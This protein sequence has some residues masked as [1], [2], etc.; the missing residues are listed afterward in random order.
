MIQTGTIRLPIDDETGVPFA[1]SLST[2]GVGNRIYT[3]PDI[4]FP[5]PF[6]NTP[7]MVAAL[8]GME[9]I[10]GTGRITIELENI[11]AE[12]FNIRVTTWDDTLLNSVMVTWIA[13][14]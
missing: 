4:A 1:W 13:H 2:V 11:Q 8:A 7:Q 10:Q 12:E 14:D 9:G 3:S 6:P 5:E